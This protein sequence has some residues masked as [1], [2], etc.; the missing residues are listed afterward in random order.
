MT[1]NEFLLCFIKKPAIREFRMTE[2]AAT[3]KKHLQIRRESEN[4]EL[5]GK[6][7]GKKE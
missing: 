6:G 1:E 5:E 7:R 4:L 3:C 2:T